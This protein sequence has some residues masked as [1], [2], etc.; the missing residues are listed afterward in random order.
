MGTATP[1][2]LKLSLDDAIQRG[3]Q[4][5]LAITE[6]RIQQQQSE[7]QRLESLDYLLPFLKAEASTGAHQYNLASFGFTPSLLSEFAP[8]FPGV[9]LGTFNPIVKVDVTTADAALDWTIGDLAAYTRYR[10]AKESLKAAFYNTQSSRGLVVLNVGNQYLKTLADQSQIDSSEALLRADEVLLKQAAAEHEAGTAARLDELR[11]R[12]QYQTQQQKVIAAQNTFD[13]DKILLKREIGVPVEQAIQLSD[14]SPYADLQ[15]MSIEDAR[16]LAYQSRQD[17]QGM[18][19]QV[20]AAQLSRSAAR[21]ERLPTLTA[22]GNYGV[23]GVTHGLYHGTFVA[24]GELKLPLF[25]EAQFRG[26]A[27]VAEA[28]QAE[29]LNKMADLKQQIDQQLRDSML[30]LNSSLALVRVSQQN[31]DLATRAL[32]DANDRF[33]AGVDDNLP[34]VQAQATLSQAQSQWIADTLSYNQAK[35]G[36]ARN[37][38]IVDTQYKMY[39]HGGHP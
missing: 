30:D 4:A 29:A 28:Q 6:A 31:V 33:A 39:L 23:T 13:K 8:L 18:Q 35:L 32:S 24:A 14:T 25:K 12:V 11:A 26:D 22:S 27:D 19:R 15:Q 38:G 9:Q 1:E 5:N 17:Y 16:H 36:L 20:R 3:I 34:V 7:G 21:Y 37:L 10:S 2:T